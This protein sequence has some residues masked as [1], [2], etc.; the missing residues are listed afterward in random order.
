MIKIKVGFLVSYDYKFLKISL[1]L[2]YSYADQ[3]F[4]A[5]DIDGKTWSGNELNIDESFWQW[6][7]DIDSLNKI[8]VYKDQFYLPELTP[9]QCD[10]RERNMLGRKMGDGGWHVQIDSD[11]YFVDF[12]GFSTQLRNYYPTEPVTIQC[13]VATLF[14]QLPSAYLIIG[15]SVEKLSFATNNPNYELARTNTSENEVLN[16]NDLVVHQSWARSEDEI[17]QK[18]S[19][20]SHKHDFNTESLFNLWNAIDEDNYHCLRNFHPLLAEEWPKLMLS[21]GSIEKIIEQLRHQKGNILV[22]RPKRSKRKNVFSRVWKEIKSK[23]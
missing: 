8:T 21:E 22:E 10:T 12:E 18:L 20:W 19:N 11:E 3:I 13:S 1:P 17:R 16:W 14:K 6:I 5:V 15:D 2:I 9:M 4:L 23:G 7:S